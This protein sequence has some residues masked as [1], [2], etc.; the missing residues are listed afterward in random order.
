[1]KKIILTILCLICICL[2]ACTA[3]N[4]INGKYISCFDNNIYYTFTKENT[5]E[6]NELWDFPINNS[7]GSYKI[8]NDKIVLYANDDRQYQRD[9]GIIYNNHICSIWNGDLPITDKNKEISMTIIENLTLSI[10]FKEDN[11]YEY[12]ITSDGEVVNTENGT[13]FTE[14]NEVVCTN[15][16]GNITTFFN[17]DNG[18]FCVEY[19]KE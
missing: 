6:T 1:M 3:N 11:T 18:V 9:L 17:T 12:T 14:G 2:T 15:N 7:T 13:Y 19:T 8:T 16:E 10:K 5:Y 4:T